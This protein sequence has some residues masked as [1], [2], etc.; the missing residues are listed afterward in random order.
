MHWSTHPKIHMMHV[1]LFLLFSKSKRSGRKGQSCFLLMRTKCMDK[2]HK[3]SCQM[4]F[5]WVLYHLWDHYSSY[6]SSVTFWWTHSVIWEDI[7][8]PNLNNSFRKFLAVF[9]FV[10]SSEISQTP[11]TTFCLTKWHHKKDWYQSPPD[12]CAGRSFWSHTSGLLYLSTFVLSDPQE[13]I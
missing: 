3:T 5:S 11:L 1:S 10:W 9:L 6:L 7:H 8:V 4:Q 2:M 12:N 13:V